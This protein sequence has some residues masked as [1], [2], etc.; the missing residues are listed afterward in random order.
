[1]SSS[2]FEAE[3]D[4]S[5]KGVLGI[6]GKKNSVNASLYGQADGRTH[7]LY[8]VSGQWN[9][10]FTIRD[11]NSGEDIET[12]DTTAAAAAPLSVPPLDQQSPW[13]SR[14][15]WAGVIDALRRGDMQGVS[16]AKNVVEEGQRKMRKDPKT[17]AEKWE[18]VFFTAEQAD[19][20]FE[21]LARGVG[22]KLMA[23]KT[24][25]VWKYDAEK[26]KRAKRPY[27]GELRPTG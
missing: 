8:T 19:P 6:G 15:A 9:E 13:E 3:I 5:G 21:K 17:S 11:E 10:S 1:M 20:V 14:K 25:G 24:M 26:A 4:F 16:N 27:H 12:Y 18:R 2:G 7:P 22:E 23:D